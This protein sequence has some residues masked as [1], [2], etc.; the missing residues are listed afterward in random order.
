MP[1][2]PKLTLPILTM[3]RMYG[4]SQPNTCQG[5]ASFQRFQQGARWFKCALVDSTGGAGTDWRANWP[6]CGRFRPA[7]EPAKTIHIMD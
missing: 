1:L 6:A 4:T 3:H 7:A 5:C 2:K